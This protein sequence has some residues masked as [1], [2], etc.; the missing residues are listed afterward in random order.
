MPSP[1][2][3]QMIAY[4]L[5]SY[6]GP[7]RLQLD[8][9]VPT[10]QVGP[11][12]V[13]IAVSKAGVNPFDWK[14]R[15]GQVKDVMPLPLPYTLG[16]D[17]VG[18]VVR[19]GDNT[20]SR[21]KVG[22]RVMTMSESLG[23]F[24]EYIA[25]EESILARVP[26]D[27]DDT[28]AATL[29]IPVLTAWLALYAAGDVKDGMRILINGA[30]GICGAFAVQFAKAVDANVTGTASTKNRDYVKTLGADQFIDYQTERFEDIL[31]ASPVDLILDFVL[32]SFDQENTNRSW[33]VLKP[34][35]TIVSVADPSVGAGAPD[36]KNGLFPTISASGNVDV[37]EKVAAQVA[38]GEVKSKIGKVFPL[39]KLK[40][41]MELN[42]R[43]GTTGR[44]IVDFL[45]KH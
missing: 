8:R 37:L 23:A 28:L 38:K 5:H 45:D 30:S 11:T 10:P 18:T 14:I 29:P 1:I 39:A 24:A 35:G 19:L 43:G 44:L 16:V 26:D 4:R 21:L 2:A 9:D 36:G 41:A 12:Q 34:Q 15:E 20:S 25:V 40:D 6:G 7:E 13:L 33:T 42:Q 31:S 22:D 3:S 32:Q 17:F 27:L